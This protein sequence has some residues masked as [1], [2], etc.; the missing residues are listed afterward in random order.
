MRFDLQCR[1]RIDLFGQRAGGL[2]PARSALPSPIP[3]LQ[4]G[5]NLL[6][7]QDEQVRPAHPHADASVAIPRHAAPVLPAAASR[8]SMPRRRCMVEHDQVD[9]QA[10]AGPER[11][12]AQQVV[13][14]VQAG[15][16]ME[17]QQHDRPVAGN[18]AG[19]QRR[20]AALPVR[21]GVRRGAQRRIAVQQRERQPLE[22]SRL[23]RVDAGIVQRRL[24]LSRGA[25]DQSSTDPAPVARPATPRQCQRFI[26][27]GRSHRPQTQA[28]RC[29]PRGCARAG[30]G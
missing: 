5:G 14:E 28:S 21:D 20:R 19:P 25:V 24:R 22:T 9:G 30:A 6:V 2:R 29:R 17:T 7:A 23:R 3:S 26:A 12:R 13:D 8:S 1:Q 18:A 27:R 4:A 16:V 15:V 10:L 11:M